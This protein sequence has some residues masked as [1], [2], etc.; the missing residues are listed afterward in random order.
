MESSILVYDGEA[1]LT[2]TRPIVSNWKTEAD[3]SIPNS[4]YR[5]DRKGPGYDFEIETDPEQ[6]FEILTF[7]STVRA[8]P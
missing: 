2:I 7:T 4:A 5:V 8:E 3:S 1:L 6:A